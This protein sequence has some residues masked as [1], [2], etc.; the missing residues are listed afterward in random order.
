M[1]LS[2]DSKLLAT[3]TL[4]KNAVAVW[5]LTTGRSLSEPLAPPGDFWGLFSVRFSPDG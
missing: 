1:A 5:D 2:A 4:V 3:F